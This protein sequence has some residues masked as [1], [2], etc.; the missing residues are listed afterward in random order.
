[1]TNPGSD[2]PD[3]SDHEARPRRRSVHVLVAVAAVAIL[4]GSVGLVAGLVGQSPEGAAEQA[5][6][7]LGPE[8]SHVANFRMRA[9][10]PCRYHPDRGGMVA[11]FDVTTSEEGQFTV[12][13]KAVTKAGADNLDIFTRHVVRVTVPFYGGRTRKQFDVVV[14]VT[15]ADRRAGYRKCRYVVNPTGAAE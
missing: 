8:A 13:L 6:D 4:V 15:K 12:D 2:R 7:P 1:M 5:A 10:G 3:P 11:H 14:P 9:S